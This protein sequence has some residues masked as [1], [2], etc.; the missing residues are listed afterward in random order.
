MRLT[1]A[2]AL[3]K[4]DPSVDGLVPTLL[5]CVRKMRDTEGWSEGR[6]AIKALGRCDFR[7]QRVLGLL[8][9]SLQNYSDPTGIIREEAVE[10]IGRNVVGLNAALPGLRTALSDK[11]RAVRVRAAAAV[12]KAT[13]DVET[14]LPVLLEAAA[15]PEDG[16]QERV[17][18]DTL[19]ITIDT[20][21]MIAGHDKRAVVGLSRIIEL[22]R[23]YSESWMRARDA[24][25]RVER[26]KYRK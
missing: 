7:D 23:P 16:S 22:E 24:F 11:V 17:E 9:E 15:A 3:S 26:E 2:L 25:K 20:L 19:E 8:V 6:A 10:A 21:E 5:D 14:C 12:W 4:M 18:A 1:A 13:T